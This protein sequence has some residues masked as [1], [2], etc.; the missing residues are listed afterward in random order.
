MTVTTGYWVLGPA[1]MLTE[2]TATPLV[3]AEAVVGPPTDIVRATAIIRNDRR[4][5]ADKNSRVREEVLRDIGF[6]VSVSM[7]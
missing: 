2:V 7:R 6:A 1:R 3:V 5:L 4:L